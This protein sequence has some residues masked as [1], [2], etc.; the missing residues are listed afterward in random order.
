MLILENFL[1]NLLTQKLFAIWP[2][3]VAEKP[4][5]TTFSQTVYSLSFSCLHVGNAWTP[6]AIHITA[7]LQT[8]LCVAVLYRHERNFRPFFGATLDSVQIRER[9][10]PTD[11][12]DSG[13]WESHRSIELAPED[14]VGYSEEEGD[15][16]QM[17][18]CSSGGMGIWSPKSPSLGI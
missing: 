9:M 7:W 6:I 18:R 12:G 2:L 16:R 13:I 11:E 5:M 14:R 3:D 17:G 4:N 10:V 15:Q 1:T 8:L